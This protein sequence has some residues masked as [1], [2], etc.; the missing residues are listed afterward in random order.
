LPASKA[1]HSPSPLS[2]TAKPT[3]L[4]M[5]QPNRGSTKPPLSPA[6]RGQG[7]ISNAG[8][9]LQGLLSPL[10]RGRR[11]SRGLPS[12][13]QK[14][15]ST[16]PTKRREQ[17]RD[18]GGEISPETEEEEQEQEQDEEEEKEGHAVGE[19]TPCEPGSS[20]SD[21][22]PLEDDQMFKVH[23]RIYSVSKSPTCLLLYMH[24]FCVL[25]L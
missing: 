24:F 3:S 6:K 4:Q 16:S 5:R 1:V 9:E 23:F 11:E 14:A 7:G 8:R 2:I 18:K 21:G 12:T 19:P 25:P 10:K 22:G 17:Y 15:S 20:P 13:A